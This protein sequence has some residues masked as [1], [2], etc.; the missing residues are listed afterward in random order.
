MSYKRT[1]HGLTK[2]QIKAC[3]AVIDGA[4]VYCR[5][6]AVRLRE[7]ERD[8]PGYICIT[9][10]RHAPKDGARQQP[11]FGAILT[12]LGRKAVTPRKLYRHTRT[13]AV[14]VRA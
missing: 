7:V 12:P 6:I 9:R 3:R 4:D 5:A 2:E 10:A 1:G 14:E 11:Y 8:F 13:H